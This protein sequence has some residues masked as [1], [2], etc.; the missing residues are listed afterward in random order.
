MQYFWSIFIKKQY[1]IL[2]KNNTW[3]LC[4]CLWYVGC[5]NEALKNCN[6][7]VKICN[8]PEIPYSI[9]IDCGVRINHEPDG[10]LN[11]DIQ[12][13]IYR[14]VPS[15]TTLTQRDVLPELLVLPGSCVSVWTP[16]STH[17]QFIICLIYSSKFYSKP[18]FVFKDYILKF[19][20]QC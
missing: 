13:Q 3:H 18:D 20:L 6:S 9:P 2:Q 5:K 7:K 8:W 15:R 4:Q 1:K 16:T 17:R 14:R 11:G 10:L 12:S 19:Y